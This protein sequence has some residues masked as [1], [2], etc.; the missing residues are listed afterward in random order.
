MSPEFMWFRLRWLGELYRL[1]LCNTSVIQAKHIN[2]LKKDS[3]KLMLSLGPNKDL[4]P[5]LVPL[6]TKMGDFVTKNWCRI[7]LIALTLSSATFWILPIN[8]MFPFSFFFFFSFLFAC[9]ASHDGDVVNETI[10]STIF[11][12]AFASY[13][14]QEAHM[15]VRRFGVHQNF[16]NPNLLQFQIP[17]SLYLQSKIPFCLQTGHLLLSVLYAVVPLYF[18]SLS[19]SWHR[20][21]VLQI[22]AQCILTPTGKS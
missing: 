13:Q 19:L 16:G 21:H 1:Y 8:I 2:S 20:Q 22:K 4:L 15:L 11:V 7:Y 10:S 14:K 18:S 5:D 17:H 12:S 9:F 3:D 6:N